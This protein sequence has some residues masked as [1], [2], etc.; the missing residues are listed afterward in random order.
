MILPRRT[1]NN[2]LKMKMC[3][4]YPNKNQSLNTKTK[5]LNNMLQLLYLELF[6]LRLFKPTGNNFLFLGPLLC[7]QVGL[8]GTE[9]SIMCRQAPTFSLWSE[10][11]LT[12]LIKP[13][14]EVHSGI[15]PVGNTWVG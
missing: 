8:S 2:T 12:P 3:V 5:N 15:V 4:R 11:H 7:D 1:F 14:P 9:W 13:E 10:K 6:C